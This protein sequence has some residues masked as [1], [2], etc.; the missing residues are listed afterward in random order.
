MDPK[1]QLACSMLAGHH[2]AF[3]VC[4]CLVSFWF[5][6]APDSSAKC[7]DHSTNDLCRIPLCPSD[8]LHVLFLALQASLVY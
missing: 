4:F 3:A 5:C 7:R 6:W 1:V 2:V 8:V